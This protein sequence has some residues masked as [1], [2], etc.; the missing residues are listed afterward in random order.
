MTK[1]VSKGVKRT[2]SSAPS[3]DNNNNNN[4]NNNGVATAD[5]LTEAIDAQPRPAVVRSLR[6][7]QLCRSARGVYYFADDAVSS[8]PGGVAHV[9]PEA[10][11]SGGALV[12]PRRGDV[13]IVGGAPID[14]S[15]AATA[16]TTPP[17]PP[18]PPPP[19][20]TTTTQ[21][22]QTTPI[23][24]A[25]R[26]QPALDLCDPSLQRL[27]EREGAIN[28]DASCTPLCVVRTFPDGNCLSH[29]ASLGVWGVHDTDQELRRAVWSTMAE[30]TSADSAT[31]EESAA[32]TAA[33]GHEVYKRFEASLLSSGM[34]PESVAAEW[35]KELEM[36]RSRGKASSTSR[37]GHAFLSDVH[38]FVLA[39]VL[40]RPLLVY[41]GATAR[42]A[43]LVGIYLPLLWRDSECCSRV[44]TCV[45]F[46]NGHYSLLAMVRGDWSN[47]T[48]PTLPLADRRGPLP[49]RFLLPDEMGSERELLTRWLS[50]APLPSSVLPSLPS[51]GSAA[52]PSPRA[53]GGAGT[54]DV[55]VGADGAGWTSPR[56]R[57]GTS[58]S[59]TTPQPPLACSIPLSEVIVRV[60]ERASRDL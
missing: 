25:T 15:K 8:V 2:S 52:T 45:F 57:S 19:L 40:R 41:G 35:T 23:S 58:S 30:A 22:T 39:N 37:R 18:P 29:A 4:N 59:P 51:G 21:T 31:S 5:E 24:P 60:P 26:L 49:V 1:G 6:R 16:P 32:A 44:P 43:G 54:S 13:P 50:C 17:P 46:H 14:A 9:D 12:L 36:F 33:A 38:C 47:G 20:P 53:R 7:C 10:P 34:P 56:R 42:M 3:G 48:T 11:P 55:G 28:A 27:A